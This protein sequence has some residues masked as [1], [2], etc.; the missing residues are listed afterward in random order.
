VGLAG[1]GGSEGGGGLDT[2]L[3]R[4]VGSAAGARRAPGAIPEGNFGARERGPPPRWF[5]GRVRA[6]ARRGAVGKVAQGSFG[7]GSLGL[8]LIPDRVS[9]PPCAS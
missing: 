2:T 7:W 3:S 6:R 4:A 8:T 1:R 9:Q 5:G